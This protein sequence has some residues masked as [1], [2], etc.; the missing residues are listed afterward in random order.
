MSNYVKKYDLG[1][2]YLD[3]PSPNC[4]YELPLLSFGD[5]RGSVNLALVYNQA[6][7]YQ[8][9]SFNVR[10]GYKL[11][12]QK[13]LYTG[14]P[15]YI[16][17]NGKAVALTV[18]GEGDDVLYTFPD[19]SGRII[20]K[21]LNE[22]Q[23][24]VYELEYPDF[25]R[26]HY[27]M[28]GNIIAAYDKYGDML[29]RY[30]YGVS[31]KL[32]SIDYRVSK[33]A[34]GQETVAKTLT[35]QYDRANLISI[36]FSCGDTSVEMTFEHAT[37][38]LTV[39][40]YS[41]VQYVLLENNRE[42]TATV[43]GTEGEHRNAYAKTCTI[44]ENKTMVLS[45]WEYSQQAENATEFFDF[46]QATKLNSTNYTFA[47]GISSALSF[48]Q[49]V[50]IIDNQGVK[51]R[52]Q[53][54]GD[55][56]MYAYEI[57]ETDVEFVTV[58]NGKKYSDSV[59]M[60]YTKDN[61]NLLQFGVV[62]EFCDGSSLTKNESDCWSIEN[63]RNMHQFDE[64]GFFV[65]TGW[66]K[67]NQYS[68]DSPLEV[69]IEQSLS[70]DPLVFSPNCIS[71][72]KWMY[73]SCKFEISNSDTIFVH[74]GENHQF[75][76]AKDLRIRFFK[77][78]KTVLGILTPLSEDVLIH[79]QTGE[80]IPLSKTNFYN[81]G[82]F[83]QMP[84]DQLFFE[85]LLR[86]KLNQRLGRNL[87]EFYYNNA[88]SVFHPNA[89][90]TF[91]VD[92]NVYYLDNYHLG[93]RQY[94]EKGILLFTYHINFDWH[95]K[96]LNIVA[97]DEN[98][99][100]ISS[101]AYDFYMD[102]IQS[103]SEDTSEV[104]YVRNK[105][106][107]TFAQYDVDCCETTSYDEEASVM[108]ITSPTGEVTTY[109]FNKVWGTLEKVIYP[110]GCIVTDTRDGDGEAVIS[111]NFKSGNF[112]TTHSF[113]Y[114]NGRLS[115]ISNGNTLHYG[116]TYGG[117]YLTGVRKCD[118][119]I[120]THEHPSTLT[121]IS[122][123]PNG[124]NPL[125]SINNTYDKYGRL[126]TAD[127]NLS[128]TYD[129]HPQFRADGTLVQTANNSSSRLAMTVDSKVGKTTRYRYTNT[130]NIS[131]VSVAN[132]ANYNDKITTEEFDWDSSQRITSKTFINHKSEQTVQENFE[133]VDTYQPTNR[134]KK[135]SVLINN[136]TQA[137]SNYYYD[138]SHKVTQES[139][140]LGEQTFVKKY[141]YDAQ[142]IT[143]IELKKNT[144]CGSNQYTYD[145]MG[146]ILSDRSTL[147]NVSYET[148]YAY[149]AAGRLYRENNPFLD[150]TFIIYYND[151]GNIVE[152]R[153]YP[154]STDV[155][156]IGAY[157][158]EIYTYD[159]NQ[160]DLLISV[161]TKPITYNANGEM[162]SFDGWD[163][164]WSKGKLSRM[165][166]TIGGGST[167]AIK[168]NLPSNPSFPDSKAYTFAYN[169]V[170]QRVGMQYTYTQGSSSLSSMQVG[171]LLSHSKT[172]TYDHAGRLM[173]ESNSKTLYDIGTNNFYIT[174]LY[175]GNA[176]IGMQYATA[177]QSQCYFYHRN[178]QGDVIGI[179]DTN[180]NLKVRYIYDAWGNCTIDNTQTTD[181][182]LAKVNPIRY[183]GYYFDVDT[184]LYYLNARY[185]SP[186]LR[187]F[188]SPDDTAYLNP[189]NPNGLNLYAYCYNDPVNYADPSGNGPITAILI[190]LGIGL[191]LGLGY[192]AYTDYSDDTS[193][194]G[195]VGWQPYLGYSMMFGSLGMA[196]GYLWPL[197]AAFLG[198]SFTFTLPTLGMLGTEGVLV[199]GATVTVTGAQ[200]LGGAIALGLGVVLFASDKRPKTNTV[201]NK[202]FEDAARAAGYNPKDPRI[203]D[204]LRRVH[205][206]IR[207][208]RLNFGWEDLVNLIKEMLG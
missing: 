56:M 94:T 126:L 185:Y 93:K 134:V 157:E 29:L 161:G 142:R 14:S 2:M 21:T 198:S 116:F 30:H 66:I 75:V 180:G 197:I 83:S 10:A 55:K 114:A 207:Q 53:Y 139:V 160:P 129:I 76:L 181:I 176:M 143:N 22:N 33:D 72:E 51:R 117:G 34:N 32:S 71:N 127:G 138:T 101:Y 54:A 15:Y 48:S 109:Y 24:P 19:D 85:D 107:I 9:V 194:N 6:M 151:I 100:T 65:L 91:K 82:F 79:K 35:F 170:G 167:W 77:T 96:L 49:Y 3:L 174:Y 64:D 20:R 147:E 130:G 171:E 148:T 187:R 80:I 23:Q 78:K 105:G 125:Y 108:T 59:Q 201:Q 73:F 62:Q 13:R 204:K 63:I 175:D 196:A 164:S 97:C 199:A 131:C 99:N 166:K 42:Y 61:K 43:W 16:E 200:I 102:M 178:L 121:T 156:F 112:E 202:Q 208:Q 192:A 26:E 37:D 159:A 193:I 190:G 119:L 103:S 25:S 189:E 87:N 17:A 133:Y 1:E 98:G 146:R 74:F 38:Q 57:G 81:I 120:E 52:V 153:A 158:E 137:V 152:V 88:K 154:Y 5:L 28:N 195:S 149:N 184:G 122:H 50:E 173:A 124:N 89:S 141:T 69:V 172:F 8:G 68:F 150:K 31:D 144:A 7:C 36:I 177:T 45:D 40:H 205:Q 84:N 140:E 18:S 135:V 115:S 183:R 203:K 163:Y 132:T 168:P 188:I 123:H 12:L 145:E 162:T 182:V 39:N 90:V 118:S 111:K 58:G 110:D 11:N 60:F 67:G 70:N 165:E 27:D 104:T 86:Y 95:E 46:T 4:I 155:P 47:Y 44:F 206:R 169:A 186:Q 113:D 128:C 136:S 179:Y 92:Q 191:G 41:G 106:L